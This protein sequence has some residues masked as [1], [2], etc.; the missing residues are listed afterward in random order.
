MMQARPSYLGRATRGYVHGLDP[1]M[2]AALLEAG[3]AVTSTTVDLV[4]QGRA[5]RAERRT[6]AYAAKQQARADADAARQAALAQRQALVESTR[7]RGTLVSVL[8]AGGLAL[9]IVAIFASMRAPVAPPMRA[10]A[11]RS[12]RRR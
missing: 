10:N 5:Q 9:G 2:I 12:R 6:A 7:S 3:T 11:G 1:D 4:G 8:A